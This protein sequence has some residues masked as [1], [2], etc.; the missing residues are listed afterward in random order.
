MSVGNLNN[1]SRGEDSKHIVMTYIDEGFVKKTCL[2]CNV[3]VYR[4]AGHRHGAI[5]FENRSVEHL[6]TEKHRMLVADWWCGG[7]DFMRLSKCNMHDIP[8]AVSGPVGRSIS[9]GVQVDGVW[10]CTMCLGRKQQDLIGELGAGSNEGDGPGQGMFMLRLEPYIVPSILAQTLRD[11]EAQQTHFA[12]GHRSGRKEQDLIGELGSGSN[13]GDGPSMYCVYIDHDEIARYS[14]RDDAVRHF[15]RV[16]PAYGSY[17][18]SESHGGTRERP[19]GQTYHFTGH[20]VSWRTVD[21][22]V[23]VMYKVWMTN[24]SSP[25]YTTDINRA[26]TEMRV[27]SKRYNG[28]RITTLSEHEMRIAVYFENGGQHLLTLTR[29]DNDN[30][31]QEEIGLIG[32]SNSAGDGPGWFVPAV[33]LGQAAVLVGSMLAVRSFWKNDRKAYVAGLMRKCKVS[34]GYCRDCGGY[35]LSFGY[36]DHL[37][38]RRGHSLEVLAWGGNLASCGPG[39]LLHVAFR[40]ETLDGISVD[41]GFE[42]LGLDRDIVADCFENGMFDFNSL[43]DIV[44]EFDALSED[45][46][47]NKQQ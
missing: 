31:N 16:W 21:T 12:I 14:S 22:F 11:R 1:I 29:V 34:S 47:E 42:A 6:Q 19:Y 23:G 45:E 46:D 37:Y 44:N 24:C 8:P 15:N 28:F 26:L 18:F 41:E 35:E 10:Y 13:E 27:T 4:T 5:R 38:C 40:S 39:K 30:F 9:R 3:C 32:A 33:V 17:S 7:C 20:V 25:F 2:L 36:N 43:E